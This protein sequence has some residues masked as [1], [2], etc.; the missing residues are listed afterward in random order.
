MAL[1]VTDNSPGAGEIAWAGLIITKDTTPYA[2]DNGDSDK[3]YLW[4]DYDSPNQLQESDSQPALNDD[5]GDRLVFLN[6]SGTHYICMQ[7]TLPHGSQIK[8]GTLP[9]TAL[10][11]DP[12]P[13][14]M[15]HPWAGAIGSI[16]SGWLHCNGASVLRSTY[17]D[18]FT[19]ISTIHGSVDGSHFTLPDLRD[20]SI[21]GAKQDDSGTPKSNV[22]GA[23]TQDGGEASHILVTS[24]MPSH[25]HGAV[26]NH[27]HSVA[28]G[29]WPSANSAAGSATNSGSQ[30]PTTSGAGGGHTHTTIGGNVTHNTLH[31]YYVMTYVIKT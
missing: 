23:L 27:T 20:V 31:P 15:V 14:G 6:I 3:K 11:E 24:E 18:L 9:L 5:D 29:Y 12:H 13:A 28:V 21:M 7:A 25:N 16:P 2:I 4:W 17:A 19:A 30:G 22:S 1:V 10:E 26:G 8:T